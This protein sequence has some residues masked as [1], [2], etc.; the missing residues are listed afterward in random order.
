MI[1]SLGGCRHVVWFSAGGYVSRLVIPCS[2]GN[3][4]QTPGIAVAARRQAEN[5]ILTP[6]RTVADKYFAKSLHFL[7]E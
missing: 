3:D 2:K 5:T 7:S 1:L 6:Y 4:D